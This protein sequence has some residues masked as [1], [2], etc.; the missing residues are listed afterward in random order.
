LPYTKKEVA[1]LLLNK[2]WNLKTK[3]SFTLG[4]PSVEIQQEF[5]NKFE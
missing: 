2:G 5:L 4:L 3:F 1:R